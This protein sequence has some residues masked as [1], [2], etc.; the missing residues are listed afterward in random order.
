MPKKNKCPFQRGLRV[1]RKAP[2]DKKYGIVMS[3]E[4]FTIGDPETCRIPGG[5]LII[6]GY[7]AVQWKIK[8]K[9]YLC[10]ERAE[11]FE[12]F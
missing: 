10:M 4:W 2:K 11:E 8:G 5:P 6:E 3:N 9:F 12:V 7:I 1:R